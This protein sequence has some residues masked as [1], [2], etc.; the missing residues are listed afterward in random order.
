[1][2]VAIPAIPGAVNP[3]ATILSWSVGILLLRN[4]WVVSMDVSPIRN[5]QIGSH[6]I[7]RQ[8]SVWNFIATRKR[9]VRL[10]V[11]TRTLVQ[12]ILV[13]T[14]SFVTVIP[15]A[16]VA[17]RVNLVRQT[18]PTV[19]S[20]TVRPRVRAM[21]IAMTRTSARTTLVTPLRVFV[22]PPITQPLVMMATAVPPG[23]FAP[24]A[25]V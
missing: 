1:M 19:S 4:G 9:R 6:A 17:R 15:L 20:V 13:T 7:R 16:N 5:A 12:L 2:P 21:R 23:T 3:A 10:T 24:T 11:M 8:D 18:N 25:V 14:N 22:A